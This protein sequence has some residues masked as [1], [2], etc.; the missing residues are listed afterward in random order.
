MNKKIFFL[1]CL[2]CFTQ[3]QNS[4]ASNIANKMVGSYCFNVFGLKIY[5][6]ELLSAN[7][8]FDYN[9]PL[10]LSITYHKNFSAKQ[11]IDKTLSEMQKVNNLSKQ[12]IADYNQ[13]LR[14][15][16]VDVAKNDNKT[17]IFLPSVGMQLLLN[18]RQVAQ[19]NNPIFAKNFFD[20]WL[21]PKAS[22]QD[23]QKALINAD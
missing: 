7:G 8:S 21:S 11:L 5:H 3:I 15:H 2:F 16:F 19:I 18:N 14:K 1:I 23:M 4:T 6:I 20:I 10:A 9:Q 17:A 12:Q 22:Y 13:I